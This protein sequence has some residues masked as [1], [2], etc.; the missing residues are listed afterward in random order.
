[1]TKSAMP[2]PLIIY[3]D[4]NPPGTGATGSNNADKAPSLIWGGAGLFDYRVGYNQTR[5]GAIGFT[6]GYIPVI[7]QVPAALAANNIAASQ[8]VTNTTMTLA[9]ASTGI[10]VLSAALT[11]W[12]SGNAVPSGALVIDG[13]PALTSYGLPSLSTGST[14]VSTYDTSTMI[15]RALR[16]V[17]GNGGDS[18]TVTIAGYDVYGY[19][20]SETIT[21][22]AGGTATGE[23]AFKF[24]TSATVSGTITNGTIGTTDVYGFPLRVDTVGYARVWFNNALITSAT[25]FVAADTTDPA[26]ATTG[27][28]RGTY[29]TA[30][31][32]DD[33]KRLQIFLA[34]D[35]SNIGSLFGVTQA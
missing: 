1:M 27:D 25:G 35:A 28:V 19:P 12:A 26:T 15:S 6:G 11:V 8:T 9:G 33:A 17:S 7:D 32:S 22:S 5:F 4:R 16:V 14:T 31:A 13:N 34:I 20:M 21:I 30:S 2:G 24:V 10:T 29:L 18:G 23:K 3:G